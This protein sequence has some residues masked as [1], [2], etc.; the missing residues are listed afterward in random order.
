MLLDKIAQTRP[1]GCR[2]CAGTRQAGTGWHRLAFGIRSP[3]R[4]R[5]FMKFATRARY[6]GAVSGLA[7]TFAAPG[8]LAAQTSA[9][10]VEPMR[11][12][13][14]N[15][16]DSPRVRSARDW[17]AV[18]GALELGVVGGI[19]SGI[20]A[21]GA[22]ALEV[23]LGDVF[24]L[25]ASA[26]VIGKQH[27]IAGPAH[28]EVMLV[29]G[30]ADGC[31]GGDVGELRLRGCL[32]LLSGAIFFG[33]SGLSPSYSPTVAWMA[34][35]IRADMTWYVTHRLGLRLALDG[36]VSLGHTPLEIEQNAQ[37]SNVGVLP[38]FGVIGGAG[39][40]FTFR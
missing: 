23:G 2:I 38:R 14:V 26:F 12:N 24:D 10:Y 18:R 25:R 9:P 13:I 21:G 27:I 33:V 5:S 15:G 31:V 16:G 20:G 4:Y 8:G 19:L 3:T 39:S 40:V 11:P 32:G 35:P 34:V 1:D 7:A 28:A 6:L 17:P 37:R 30:R 29:A 22:A 36:V